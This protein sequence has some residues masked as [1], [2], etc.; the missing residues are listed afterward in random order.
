METFGVTAAQQKPEVNLQ[1]ETGAVEVVI[2][3][4]DKAG[5]SFDRSNVHLSHLNSTDP[6]L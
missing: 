4:A 3:N 5:I 6:K 2:S 1:S